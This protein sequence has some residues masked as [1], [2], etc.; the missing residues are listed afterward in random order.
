MLPPYAPASSGAGPALFAL[1]ALDFFVC[2]RTI[3]IIAMIA[4]RKAAPPAAPPAIAPTGVAFASGVGVAATAADVPLE[5]AEEVA[6]E[7]ADVENVEDVEEDMPS[8][9]G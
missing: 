4:I 7:V 2:R 8:T 6:E 9:G 5:V 1:D 3:H